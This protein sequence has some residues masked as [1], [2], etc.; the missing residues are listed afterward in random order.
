MIFQNATNTKVTVGSTST[1][2]LAANS[3]RGFATIVNDSD[4]T[5]YLGFG[6]AAV[7]NEGLRIA[8]S[9]GGYEI[10]STNLFIGPIYGISTS[11]SKVVSVME[12]TP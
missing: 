5:I 9:G 1:L 7:L 8:S 12:A 4:E 3:A 6:E 2:I 11:G 10:N